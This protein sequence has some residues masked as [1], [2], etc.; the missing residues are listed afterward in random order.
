MTI[1]L[2]YTLL[3][4]FI[5]ARFIAISPVSLGF[6]VLLIALI[7]SILIVPLITS[8]FRFIMFIIYVGGILVIFS[9][10]AALQ[11]NQHITNWSWGFLPAII[12]AALLTIIDLQPIT[13]PVYRVYIDLLFTYQNR[14]IIL[15]IGLLL[16]LALIIVVKVSHSHEG[17]LRPFFYVQAHSKNSPCH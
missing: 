17:P 16:F 9:Y 6:T 12:I 4:T 1:F 14:L 13:V 2:I 15:F 3:I 11:P 5:A 8:W 7:I 10:F